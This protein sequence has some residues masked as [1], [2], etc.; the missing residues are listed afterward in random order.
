MAKTLDPALDHIADLYRQGMSFRDIARLVGKSHQVVAQILKARK[1]ESRPDMPGRHPKRETIEYLG[2][3]YT[4]TTK[5]YWRCTQFADRHNLSVRIWEDANGK[6]VPKDWT[7]FFKDGNRFNLAVENIGCTSK[8]DWM[9]QRLADPDNKA[10]A[11]CAGCVGRLMRSVNET[12]TPSLKSERMRKTWE[13]RKELYGA[14][15]NKDGSDSWTTRKER[16]GQSGCK[17]PEIARK[18]MSEAHKKK[19]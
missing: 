8:S 6:K 17:D 1:V 3:R 14:R 16:Y 11:Y 12:I 5:G 19:I 18:N 4:W 7:T 2:L 10:L 9:K 13:K 15:G